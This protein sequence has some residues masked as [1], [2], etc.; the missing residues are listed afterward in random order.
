MILITFLKINKFF[1][2]FIKNWLVFCS[3]THCQFTALWI[4]VRDSRIL[5]LPYLP[6]PSCPR[7]MSKTLYWVKIRLK[8]NLSKKVINVTWWMFF[9]SNETDNHQGSRRVWS[10]KLSGFS[11]NI[12]PCLAFFK[13]FVSLKPYWLVKAGVFFRGNRRKCVPNRRLS[14]W[15]F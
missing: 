5:S 12:W 10:R 15:E 6:F 2:F 13:V 4:T 11:I 3:L 14:S 7:W 9:Q 8:L 1:T